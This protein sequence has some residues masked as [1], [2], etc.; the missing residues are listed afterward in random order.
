M[1]LQT[2]LNRFLFGC[3]CHWLR[4]K[5]AFPTSCL[6]TRLY[7]HDSYL[8]RHSLK[9][10][11]STGILFVR[12]FLKSATAYAARFMMYDLSWVVVRCRNRQLLHGR[13]SIQ[14]VHQSEVAVD[15]FRWLRHYNRYRK[16]RHRSGTNPR[17]VVKTTV[18][19][20]LCCEPNRD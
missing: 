8:Q 4:A 18:D 15:S 14:S 12:P 11:A 13:C 20:T 2:G 1:I 10:P 17:A 3:S 16:T 7:C 9:Q 19:R 5:S 6:Q